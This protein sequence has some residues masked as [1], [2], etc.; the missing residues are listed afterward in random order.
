MITDKRQSYDALIALF[1]N[2]DQIYFIVVG[3]W[4]V[5]YH[6]LLTL[7]NSTIHAKTSLKKYPLFKYFNFLPFKRYLM[8]GVGT[9]SDTRLCKELKN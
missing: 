7:N 1:K 3:F 4:H 6:L 9:R 2:Q 8:L 5:Y